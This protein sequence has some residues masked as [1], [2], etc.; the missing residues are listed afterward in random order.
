[1]N[2]GIVIF[3]S[4]DLQN[5][6]NSFRKHYDPHYNLIPPHVTLINPFQAT[7]TEANELAGKLKEIAKKYNPINLQAYK[8]SS[9]QPV[10]N[11]IYLKLKKNETLEQLQHEV[12]NV[13]NVEPEYAFVPHITISQQLTNIDHANIYATLRATDVNISDIID[14]FHILYQ[15]ENK[16]WTVFETIRL[17]DLNE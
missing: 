7:E 11:V 3:P 6:A 9:F 4:K 5:Y 15:L 14:R 13:V 8:I 1:M 17:G 10:T 2:L 16:S 12:L